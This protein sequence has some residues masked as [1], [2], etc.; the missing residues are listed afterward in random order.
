M[1]DDDLLRIELTGDLAELGEVPVTDV[2]NL[3]LGVQTAAA[4][5][6]AKILGRSSIEGRGRRGKVVETATRL[7]LVGLER[8]S[9]GVVMRVPRVEEEDRLLTE[10]HSL[11]QMAVDQVVR[12]L[13]VDQPDPAIARTLVQ[14]ANRIG[15]G[16]RYDSVN[17]IEHPNGSDR[18]VVSL[19][20]ARRDRMVRYLESPAAREAD[21]MLVGV[22]VEA[23]FEAMSARLRDPLN[24]AVEVVFP[25][26][27]ADA[28]QAALREQAEFDAHVVYDPRSQTAG[29][30][31]L[32]RVMRGRQLELE[33][34]TQRFQQASDVETL[35]REQGVVPI[36]DPTALRFADVTDAEIDGFLEALGLEG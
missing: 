5:S 28:I 6:A 36:E 8:G 22:L 23:D 33:S 35:V 32:R 26:S 16:S 12:T 2:A 18:R 11:G 3:L 21:E 19:D 13:Q 10:P 30:V 20:A 7:R 27:L 1:T 25:D 24:Q 14:L 17:F 31:E 9:V 15:V 4:A 29:R 34:I